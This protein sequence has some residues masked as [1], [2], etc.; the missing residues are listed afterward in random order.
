MVRMPTLWKLLML[1]AVLLM[2]LGM[3]TATASTP[4]A[5]H[6]EMMAGMPMG[7][8][9]DQSNKRAHSDGLATCSMVC[10]STLPAQELIRDETTPRRHQLVAPQM[11]ETLHGVLPE[12]ATPPPRLA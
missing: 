1:I 9:P 6:H 2:P 7:H 12:I 4:V 11:A 3:E 8:C 10:A 5:G